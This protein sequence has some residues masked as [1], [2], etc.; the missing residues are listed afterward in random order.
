M[1]FLR[2]TLAAVVFGLMPLSM[3]TAAPEIAISLN[4]VT[5]NDNSG[6]AS[7]G[8][9]PQGAPIT[10]TFVVS[11]SGTTTL[12]LGSVI[13]GPGFT[14]TDQ[15]STSVA[16]GG[17]TT[18]D[19]RLNATSTGTVNAGLT[20]ATNDLDEAPYNFALI[21]QVG[22]PAPEIAVS[23]EGVDVINSGDV[24]FG[25]T[26]QGV[27]VSKVF[28]VENV[29]SQQLIISD[30]AVPAGYTVTDQ[31]ANSIP[32]GA[33]TTFTVRLNAA[34]QSVFSGTVTF[35]TNDA[36]EDPFTIDISGNVL[37]PA[38]EIQ[39]FQNVTEISDAGSFGF[40]S[41]G[42]GFPVEREFTIRNIGVENLTI[43]DVEVPAGYLLTV[44]P[45]SPVTP[46][47]ETTFT[48]Q[49]VASNV[50]S[51]NGQIRFDN[52]DSNE[53]P[54]NFTVSGQVNTPAP[55]IAVTQNNGGVLD[56]GTFG[57]GTTPQNAAL[58]RTFTIENTGFA[59]LTVGNVSVPAGYTVL[60]QPTSPVAP[61]DT[62]DFEVQLDATDRGNFNGTIQF[63]TNVTGRNPFNF[64]VAG[65]VN[66]PAPEVAVDQ[67]GTNIVDNGTF[68]FGPTTQGFPI[69]KVFTVENTGSED[70]TVTNLKV[71]SGFSI[72][73]TPASPVTPGNSTTFEVQFDADRVGPKSGTLKFKTNDSDE[74]DFNFLIG[75]NANPQEPEIVVE[76]DGLNVSDGGAF[77]FAAT[78]VGSPIDEVF[79]IE[80]TG[81]ADLE[82]KTVKVPK[83]YLV[84]AQPSFAP[85]A[86]SGTTS[87]TIQTRAN[88][89]GTFRGQLKFKNNDTTEKDFNLFLTSVVNA[90]PA[91][92]DGPQA[93]DPIFFGLDVGTPANLAGLQTLADR[94]DAGVR[95]GM[96]LTRSDD[97]SILGESLDSGALSPVV[98]DADRAAQRA[99]GFSY[100][101]DT[102]SVGLSHD[103]AL[104]LDYNVGASPRGIT[105]LSLGV[106]TRHG[107]T[108]GDIEEGTQITLTSENAEAELGVL[109]ISG[110]SEKYRGVSVADDAGPLAVWYVA[111]EDRLYVSAIG[112]D[113]PAPLV[114]RDF[115]LRA[116]NV[117]RATFTIGVRTERL[118]DGFTAAPS[119]DNVVVTG[120]IREPVAGDVNR[121]GWADAED[122]RVVLRQ[123]G[124]RG[125]HLAGDVNTDGKVDATDLQSVLEAVGSG[126]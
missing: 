73:S 8:S 90:A 102:W 35:A 52:N 78:T 108:L 49:L 40:G 75:A 106:I 9:T 67:D 19:V 6:S 71:P 72:L 5:I 21:G 26:F 93:E 15:P 59:A 32:V 95:S 53:D 81:T 11:N 84:I 22:L 64:T 33:E 91:T 76:N 114:V 113:D 58:T 31:P 18:F 115:R 39:V 97:R 70:L 4:G 27:T 29:G 2:Q 101:S 63:S 7:F 10:R 24:S 89:R 111:D 116:G 107:G 48:V 94:F 79:D 109:A 43:G 20:L 45:T 46:N 38:P 119:I 23:V 124:R 69:S 82:V 42:E 37:A 25:S 50:G 54:F 122:I 126:D 61:G 12:N 62:T 47:S 103:F 55:N 110:G 68:N 60:A 13:V 120:S 51:F 92:F 83:G 99:A 100:V 123:T 3:A 118:R 28:T 44:A 87:F 96:W 121:D 65:R 30:V 88:K 105:E 112:F 36:N 17:T 56:G 41:T 98:L 14:V 104:M 34:T 125:E 74:K 85:I 117:A 80:N 77:S 57:F 1:G 86:P 16:A 66:E